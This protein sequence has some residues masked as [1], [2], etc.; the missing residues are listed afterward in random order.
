MQ[1]PCE[2]THYDMFYS[3][4][5]PPL[6]YEGEGV[7]TNKQYCLGCRISIMVASRTAIIDH[8][9]IFK[10]RR[11]SPLRRDRTN[12]NW[13]IGDWRQ[14]ISHNSMSTYN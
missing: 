1:F 2:I 13:K 5:S 10:G 12:G 3:G 7:F 8:G 9:L 4:S 11:M 14:L 6:C